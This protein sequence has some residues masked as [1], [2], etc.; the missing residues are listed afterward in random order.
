MRPAR[1]EI[2]INVLRHRF[3]QASDSQ[4]QTLG[5]KLQ[6][7]LRI[8]KSRLEMAPAQEGE[9][10]MATTLLFVDDNLAL[11]QA[12]TRSIGDIRPQWR[13][14]LAHTLAEA[15][16]I[17]N[18][19]SPDAAV[20]DVSLPDG[21]GLD[22]L[23]EFKRNRPGLPIIIISGDDPEELRL[24]VFNRGAFTFLAKPFSAPVL[25]NQIELAISASRDH[26]P[27]QASPPPETGGAW[28]N[29][30]A[31]VIRP[32][33]QKLAVYDPEAARFNRLILK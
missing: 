29:P 28:E 24:E 17:Y 7:D 21:N 30:H 4:L 32:P 23:S 31:L 27:D 19:Y 20:L 12:A 26:S 14:L 2:I 8:N 1:S 13:F 16:R 11:V 18:Q 22:L 9:R 25:V 10:I 6:R 15:R 3:P 33:S 5:E